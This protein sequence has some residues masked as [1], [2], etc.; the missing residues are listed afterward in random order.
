MAQLTYEKEITGLIV[1]DPYNDF[2]SEGGKVWD[3]IKG[4][5]EGN[6]CVPHMVQVLEA[7]R[8]AAIRV[9]YAMHRRYRPGDYETWKYIAPIQRSAW[10]SK[11]FEFGT[12]GGE[13]RSEFAP[14]PGDVVTSEHWGSSGFASTDLDLQL[15]KHGIEKVIV[16][17]LIAHTCVE[18][19]VRYAAE[20]GYEVTV[21]KDATTSYSD[22]HM[23]AALEVNIPNYASAVVTADEIV[24]AIT[25]KAEMRSTAEVLAHHFKC[26]ADRDLDGIMADY[27]AEALF[28]TTEGALRGPAAIR[29]V[30]EKLFGEFAK[31]GASLA[32]KRRLVEGDYVYTVWTAE[33]PDNSYELANDVFAVQ[34]GMI[35]M[36]AFTAKVRPKPD[37]AT[38]NTI[39]HQ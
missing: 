20:L 26:F 3:R 22:D 7:A 10:K 38:P 39:S 12:W 5:A 6:H 37:G 25:R 23:H 16:I 9:F 35:Q 29:G 2:I 17:G 33:T 19:T 11:A 32:S 28:F 27:A 30:F 34:N 4:V 21:V 13:I 8:K 18:A 24:E 15:K 36:Q 1:V 14:Q 31:P